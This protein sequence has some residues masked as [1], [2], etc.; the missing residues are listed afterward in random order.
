MIQSDEPDSIGNL[1]IRNVLDP[2]VIQFNGSDFSSTGENR[3]PRTQTVETFL[4]VNFSVEYNTD[5]QN[6]E[7]RIT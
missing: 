6:R 3:F 1:A 4:Y 5:D 7:D 2:Y